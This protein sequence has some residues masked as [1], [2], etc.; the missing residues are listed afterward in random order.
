MPEEATIAAV[1]RPQTVQTLLKDLRALGIRRGDT[2]IVHSAMSR[3]G[4]VCGREA[5]VVQALLNAVGPLGTLV[6]PAHSTD[7]SDPAEWHCPPVPEAWHAEI[8]AQMPAYRRRSTPTRGIG[9][10]P[11]C[12][13]TWPGV[14]RSAHPHVSW[15][16]HGPGAAWLLRGHRWNRS[17]FGMNSPAGRLYRRNAK[18]LLLGVG[19]GNCTLLHMTETLDPATPT[20]TQGAAVRGLRG[21]RWVNWQEIEMDSDRFAELGAAYEQEGGVV[22]HGRVGAADCRV[23]PARPLVDYGVRWLTAHPRPAE[24]ETSAAQPEEQP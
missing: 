5:A 24:E 15:C 14:R 8:R 2:L 19:Y 7:N 1:E 3:I 6:M 22:V 4:W 18:V 17:G 10:V 21:R 9:R 13:R 20:V 16:A 11:E 23:V 12:F